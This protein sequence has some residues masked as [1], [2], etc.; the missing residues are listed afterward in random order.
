MAGG[1]ASPQTRG[2]S[3]DDRSSIAQRHVDADDRACARG[4][5][6]PQVASGAR[7]DVQRARRHAPRRS[8]AATIA[9]SASISALCGRGG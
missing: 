3:R 6:Q 1:S 9:C 7:P 4:L 5:E 2:T 8:A